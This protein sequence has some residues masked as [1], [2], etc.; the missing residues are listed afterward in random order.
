MLNNKL[1]SERYI[2]TRFITPAFE[3][4]EWRGYYF[5]NQNPCPHAS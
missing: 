2:F 1:L 4:E 3:R 5:T